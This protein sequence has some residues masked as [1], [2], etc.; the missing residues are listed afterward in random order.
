VRLTISD[1]VGLLRL[2][3]WI[4]VLRVWGMRWNFVGLGIGFRFMNL[5]GRKLR[6]GSRCLTGESWLEPVIKLRECRNGGL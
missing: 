6:F 1:F 2:R 3:R 5:G 4:V